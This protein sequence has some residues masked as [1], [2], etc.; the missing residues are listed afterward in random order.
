MQG[1]IEE[2]TLGAEDLRTRYFS[3]FGENAAEKQARAKQT[4]SSAKSHV[5]PVEVIC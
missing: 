4:V 2:I 1:K 3:L 5:L